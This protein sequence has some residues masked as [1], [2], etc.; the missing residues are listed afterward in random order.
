MS[1]LEDEPLECLDGPSECQG[2]V[3]LRYP[4]SASGKWFPR[5][6]RHWSERVLVQEGIDRRYPTH[7][8]PDF[9]PDYAG[10]RWDD[11]Y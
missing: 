5:C 8:P 2:A 11:D 9:D 10:E 4:L 3:E 7:A 1:P 6:D